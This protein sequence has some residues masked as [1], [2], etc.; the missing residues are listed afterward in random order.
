M[1]VNLH[2]LPPTTYQ[3]ARRQ[4]LAVT[5]RA[6]TASKLHK[7]A[8]QAHG[9]QEPR[10]ASMGYIKSLKGIT[11]DL[12]VTLMFELSPLIRATAGTREDDLRSFDRTIYDRVRVKLYE[13][14]EEKAPAAIDKAADNTSGHN[15]RE[16]KRLLGI[17]P[18]RDPGVA[19][20]LEKFREDNVRLITS[21]ADDQLARVK[22]VLDA[23]FGLRAEALAEKLQEQFGATESKAKLIA[24]DQ[25]L[26]LNGNLSQIRQ[27]NAGIEEYI[28]TTSG[29]ER[30]RDSHEANEGKRFRWD[31]PPVETGHPGQD[32]QCRCTPYPVIPGLTEDPSEEA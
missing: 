7:A 32:Y 26:K 27:T 20:P 29:D 5:K 18:R 24:R 28:W 22:A 3:E 16:T 11:N 13:I 30:V 2:A 31:V 4:G 14:V 25:T 15:A 1:S 23:N 21:I 12:W 17:D 6:V 8:R 9:P 19:G 10:A